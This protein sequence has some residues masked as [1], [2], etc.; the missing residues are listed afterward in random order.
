MASMGVQLISVIPACKTG[1]LLE[2]LGKVIGVWNAHALGYLIDMKVAGGE[3]LLGL[4]D[5]IIHQVFCEVDAGFLLEQ[6]A[7]MAL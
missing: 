4:F 2:D 7:E 1:T 5:A 6:L 3:K